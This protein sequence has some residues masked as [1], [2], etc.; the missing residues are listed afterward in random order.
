MK[1]IVTK[2]GLTKVISGTTFSALF[3]AD[4]DDLRRVV[5]FEKAKRQ[6]YRDEFEG[7]VAQ[8][9]YNALQRFNNLP[10]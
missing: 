3:P 10:K 4:L 1:T 8:R 2:D 6:R 7:A 5:D 9:T